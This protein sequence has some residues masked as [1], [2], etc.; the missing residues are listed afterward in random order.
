MISLDARNN[1]PS[2][3]P[4]F[5]NEEAERFLKVTQR[6]QGQRQDWT[7]VADSRVWVPS[8]APFCPWQ[9]PTIRPLIGDRDPKKGAIRSPPPRSW[10]HG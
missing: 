1:S 4:P 10:K 3:V 2:R 5:M 9:A 7:Q 8:P 6:L